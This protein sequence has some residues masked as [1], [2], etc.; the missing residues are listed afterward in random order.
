MKQN[1]IEYISVLEE[2]YGFI[3]F[4]LYIYIY[5][6]VKCIFFVGFNFRGLLRILFYRL[7]ELSFVF[8]FGF[9]MVNF[10]GSVGG[11][12]KVDRFFFLIII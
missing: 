5:D 8:D 10:W 6:D 3:R 9:G 1:G 2:W 12:F 11:F 4:L 7:D